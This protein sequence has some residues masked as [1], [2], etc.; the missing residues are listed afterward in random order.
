MTEPASAAMPTE[1]ARGAS[2]ENFSKAS[3]LAVHAEAI[4]TLGRRVVRDVIE[5]GERLT[6]VRKQCDYGE[7]LAWLDREFEWTEQH[8][9]RLMRTYELSL[10]SDNL[11][12]LNIPVS[13]LYLL[14]A[15]STPAPA[16]QAIIAA[17]QSGDKITMTRV[18]EV[19]TEVRSDNLPPRP[20]SR[21]PQEVITP[22]ISV[23]LVVLA[24]EHLDAIV[25][26]MRKMS[27]HQRVNFQ[28][29]AVE[30]LNG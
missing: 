28:Q 5:I 2:L 15:P 20:H 24:H 7:W 26:L 27:P 25:S 1:V 4:R 14:A 16:R 17:A 23:Q 29:E 3:A 9:R 18:R 22:D 30:R 10:K 21:P 8:A 19:I 11:F 6:L 13:G 12:D